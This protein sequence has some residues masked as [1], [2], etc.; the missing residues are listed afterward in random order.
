VL[1]ESSTLGL[2]EATFNNVGALFET[3][4]LATFAVF[5]SVVV[6]LHEARPTRALLLIEIVTW[7]IWVQV[8]PSAE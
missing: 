3:V 2:A 4:T 7:A 8:I 5:K 6:P 1:P